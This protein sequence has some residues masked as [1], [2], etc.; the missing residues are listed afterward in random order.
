MEP[1]YGVPVDEA[2]QEKLLTAQVKSESMRVTL[3]TP[4][5]TQSSTGTTVPTTQS[6]DPQLDKALDVLRDKIK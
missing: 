2:G 5:T 1:D 3:E 4:A 6:I